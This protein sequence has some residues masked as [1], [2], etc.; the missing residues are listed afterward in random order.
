MDRLDALA[1]SAAMILEP[2]LPPIVGIALAL[3]LA[4]SHGIALRRRHAAGRNRPTLWRWLGLSCVSILLLLTASRIV[5][6]TD[7]ER[8]TLAAG[9]S[10]P[11][12]F[13][14]IDRSPDMAVRDLNGRSRIEVARQDMADLIER[15]P[16]AR[17]GV[18]GFSSAPALAWPLSADTWSLKP[19]LD[20]LMPYPYNS[21]GMSLANA[22]AADV[23][24]RYQVINAAQQYPG[25]LILVFYLGAGAPES[26]FPPRQFDLPPG[27]VNGGAVL[28]YGTTLGGPIPGTDVE[29]S[30]VDQVTLQLIAGQLD[31]PY[32]PRT[33]TAPLNTVLPA[34]TVEAGIADTSVLAAEREETYWIPALCAALLLL[35][36]LFLVLREL[37][38]SSAGPDLHGM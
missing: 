14:L 2:I 9:H 26:R 38:R 25:A 30:S 3:L 27:S 37:R 7:E 35:A 32:R 13:L 31:V 21:E 24:L 17:F 20:Q 11:S 1:G 16:R 28:G 4:V 6:P 34:G 10:E 5:I 29:R 19:S 18:I 36:E 8:P 15:Y 22:G 23:V 33:D 12:V